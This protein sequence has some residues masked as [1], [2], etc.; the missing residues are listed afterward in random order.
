MVGSSR[1][2]AGLTAAGD[3]MQEALLLAEQAAREVLE[4]DAIAFTYA[5]V[6]DMPEAP[7]TSQ[8]GRR[9]EGR[10]GTLTEQVYGL[11]SADVA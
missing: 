3:S 4:D 6:T 7:Q 10:S 5:L 1:S 9:D 8:I 2:I 11:V